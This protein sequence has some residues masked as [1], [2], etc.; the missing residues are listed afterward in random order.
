MKKELWEFLKTT[1]KTRSIQFNCEWTKRD[2]TSI[3]T[4]L[5]FTA[6]LTENRFVCCV[7]CVCVYFLCLIVRYTVPCIVHVFHIVYT[8]FIFPNASPRFYSVWAHTLWHLGIFNTHMYAIIR[9]DDLLQTLFFHDSRIREI[10]WC[11]QHKAKWKTNPNPNPN[12]S[13][14]Q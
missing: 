14:R 10:H 8:R 13:I 6:A 5:R 9:E 1:A 12:S 4:E 3:K 2:Y 11:E 7:L